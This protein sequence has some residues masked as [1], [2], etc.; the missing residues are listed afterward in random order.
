MKR[1]IGYKYLRADGSSINDEHG[2]VKYTRRWQTIPGNGAYVGST[3]DGLCAGGVG[4]IIAEMECRK[5]LPIDGPDGVTCYRDVRVVR[6]LA[7]PTAEPQRVYYAALAE[8]QRVYNAALAEPQRVYYAAIAEPQRVY[9]AATAEPRRVYN[10]ATAESLRV[11]Y[12]A[13][14]E[15][16]RAYYAATAEPRRVYDA[17]IAESLRAYYAATA[18]AFVLM[19][20]GC[21]PAKPKGGKP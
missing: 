2:R 15:S 12:A 13:T 17:A 16:L 3:W 10:A 1:I 21:K 20:R 19:M 7:P 11:Y 8:P 6:W 18:E 14:A 9:E 5:K 4:E